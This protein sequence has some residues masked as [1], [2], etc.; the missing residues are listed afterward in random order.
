MYHNF[1]VNDLLQFILGEIQIY[2]PAN[3]M[4]DE[5]HVG[6]EIYNLDDMNSYQEV[7]MKY[8]HRKIDFMDA[9]HGKIK[10]HLK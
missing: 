6:L 9:E 2:L 5:T 1:L 4:L 10:L 7:E 8:G 3:E